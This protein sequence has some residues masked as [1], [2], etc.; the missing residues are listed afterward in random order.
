MVNKPEQKSLPVELLEENEGNPNRMTARE[1]DLLVDNLQRT[2]LTENIVVRPL[3]NGKY[4]VVSGHHR[5]KAA[6]FL[7]YEE[8]PCAIIV[9]PKFDEEAEMFQLIRMNVIKGKLDPQAFTDMYGKVAGKYG[10]EILQDM[11]GFAEEAEFKKLIL[12]TAKSLPKE[13]QEKFKEGAQEIKTINQLAKL[14]NKLFTTY[15][16]TLPYSYMIL[17][18][19]G[20]QNFWLRIENKT[21]KALQLI[22]E[23]CVEEEVSMDDVLGEVIRRI[24]KGDLGEL[25]QDIVDKAPKVV[26]PTGFMLTPTKDNIEAAASL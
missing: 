8:V 23:L 18:Y 25:M 11:F 5:L 4:R 26:L 14:L 24:A 21:F 19:G 7:G 16:D 13:L 1:F 9:D 3:G 22:G 6:K 10:D 2:G 20:Q 17:D 12:A 15:G